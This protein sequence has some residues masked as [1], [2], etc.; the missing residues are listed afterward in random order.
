MVGSRRKDNISGEVAQTPPTTAEGVF[1]H[2]RRR[3]ATLFIAMQELPH[4][5]S[6]E[7]VLQKQRCAAPRRMSMSP[8]AVGGDRAHEKKD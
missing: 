7:E 2:E 8:S 5:Q 6:S 3:I 4:Y 1:R